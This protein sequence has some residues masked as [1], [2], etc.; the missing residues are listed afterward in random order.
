MKT[1][2]AP[3]VCLVAVSLE[4]IRDLRYTAA[5]PK[6]PKTRVQRDSSSADQSLKPVVTHR[7]QQH[8]A[9]KRIHQL[10]PANRWIIRWQVGLPRPKDSSSFEIEVNASLNI[11]MQAISAQVAKERPTTVQETQV[12]NQQCLS[13]SFLKK[14]AR[15]E[16]TRQ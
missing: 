11:V 15:Y 13:T 5:S 16:Q 10:A 2:N 3:D 9:K 4:L 8:W 14:I 6:T 7:Q 1:F 12:G